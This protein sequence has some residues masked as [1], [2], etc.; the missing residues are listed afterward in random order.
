MLT[1]SLK[2]VVLKKFL[3]YYACFQL[4]LLQDEIALKEWTFYLRGA[5]RSCQELLGGTAKKAN[6]IY[7]TITDGSSGNLAA[8]APL[9]PSHNNSPISTLRSSDSRSHLVRGASTDA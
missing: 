6:K 8:L 4:M 9:S 2:T 5:F 7:G 1:Q 3:Y